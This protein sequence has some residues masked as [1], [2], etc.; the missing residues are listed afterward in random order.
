MSRDE[1]IGGIAAMIMWCEHMQNVA[2]DGDIQIYRDQERILRGALKMLKEQEPKL[3]KLE[4]ALE[5]KKRTEPEPCVFCGGK[6]VRKQLH[7]KP[8]PGEYVYKCEHHKDGSLKWSYLE[9]EKCGRATYAYC[10]EDQS[11]KVWNDGEAKL[12]ERR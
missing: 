7:F 12:K 3:V 8:E 2:Y 1:I 5:K 4:N 6:A 9:C 11:T 10:Y